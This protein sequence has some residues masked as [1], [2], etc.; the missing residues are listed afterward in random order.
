MSRIVEFTK[1]AEFG[2]EPEFIIDGLGVIEYP[3][4]STV[5]LKLY[6]KYGKRNQVVVRFAWTLPRWRLC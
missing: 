3:S 6:A 5:R 1:V 2:T 4:P